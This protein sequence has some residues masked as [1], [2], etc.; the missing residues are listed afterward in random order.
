MPP[1]I[2]AQTKPGKSRPFPSLAPTLM[3]AEKKVKPIMTTNMLQKP[4]RAVVGT[5][6]NE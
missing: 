2:T 1:M 5:A 6:S 4:L 3:L